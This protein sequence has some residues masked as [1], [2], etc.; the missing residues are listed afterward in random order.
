MVNRSDINYHHR[1]GTLRVFRLLFIGWTATVTSGHLSAASVP[2]SQLLLPSYL[3]ER[4]GRDNSVVSERRW[5]V[6]FLQQDNKTPVSQAVDNSDDQLQQPNGQPVRFLELKE[7]LRQD[8]S[9]EKKD[10]P[11]KTNLGQ[12][13]KPAN[14]TDTSKTK[15]EQEKKDAKKTEGSKVLDQT[16]PDDPDTEMQQGERITARD[17]TSHHHTESLPTWGESESLKDF[18]EDWLDYV[19]ELLRGPTWFAA[20]PK[21]EPATLCSENAQL[22]DRVGQLAWYLMML[23]IMQEVSNNGVEY[24]NI[25]HHSCCNYRGVL[26]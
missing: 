6:M 20:T 25:D 19:I 8:S 12:N 1:N 5:P 21:R 13:T 24:V 4:D 22:K 16:I 7:S 23:K 10:D 9:N 2:L 3:A 26:Y 14:P 18:Y 11:D 15:D 17:T